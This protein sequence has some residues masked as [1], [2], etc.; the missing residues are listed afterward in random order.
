MKQVMVRYKVKSDRVA[1]NEDLVRAVYHEL[2][3]TDPEAVRYATFRLD[4]G[5]S[6]VHIFVAETEEAHDALQRLTAF[7]EFQ[8]ELGER[9][10]EQPT[11]TKLSSVGSFRLLDE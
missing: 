1:E 4:D 11:V 3:S 2:R 6:F 10:D 8:R 9:C 7:Q 5:V